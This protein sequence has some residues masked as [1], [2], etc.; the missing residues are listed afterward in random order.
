MV[1]N[2]NHHIARFRSPRAFQLIATQA[3]RKTCLFIF[4][5]LMVTGTMML[6]LLALLWDADAKDS[7]AGRRLPLLHEQE[8]ERPWHPGQWVHVSQLEDATIRAARGH[9]TRL[10]SSPSPSETQG[11]PPGND[12]GMETPRPASGTSSDDDP[13]WSS[14]APHPEPH[15]GPWHDCS[16]GPFPAED[17]LPGSPALPVTEELR[18]HADPHAL[19]VTE[20]P[21]GHPDQDCLPDSPSG[22]ATAASNERPCNSGCRSRSTMPYTAEHAFPPDAEP[23]TEEP[24]G[25][26]AP[27]H[28]PLLIPTS[29]SPSCDSEEAANSTENLSYDSDRTLHHRGALRPSPHAVPVTELPRGHSVQDRVL[30]SPPPVRQQPSK[31]RTSSVTGGPALWQKDWL[32]PAG[33]LTQGAADHLSTTSR[34]PEI[35]DTED[36]SALQARTWLMLGVNMVQAFEQAW[37][38]GEHAPDWFWDIVD[39]GGDMCRAGVQVREMATLFSDVAAQRQDTMEEYY[40]QTE[41]IR[42]RIIRAWE[43]VCAHYFTCDLPLPHGLNAYEF[44]RLS[45]ESLRQQWHRAQLAGRQLVTPRDHDR[46]ARSRSPAR[47]QARQSHSAPSQGT[48]THTDEAGRQ[49]GAGAGPDEEADITALV[50]DKWLL[51]PKPKQRPHNKAKVRHTTTETVILRA[52]WKRGGNPPLRA[53]PA[54]PAEPSTP[55]PDRPAAAN[56]TCPIELDDDEKE[57][58]VI[59]TNTTARD[60]AVEVWQALFEFEPREAIDPST[61]PVVPQSTLDNIVET[62]L[63]KP[64]SEYQHMVM[65]STYFLGRVADDVYSAMER[66]RALRARLRDEPSG[67]KGPDSDLASLMQKSLGE[68]FSPAKP[69]ILY[70]LKEGLQALSPGAA[71]ARARQLQRRL[72]DHDGPLTVDRALLDS[73][74]WCMPRVKQNERKEIGTFASLLGWP[75]GGPSWKGD[76]SPRQSPRRSAS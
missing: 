18:G 41:P 13:A 60:E 55:P 22:R 54:E 69:Q 72:K 31:P 34:K 38:D 32:L 62:L 71:I 39:M 44:A 11:I 43:V 51:K 29:G 68:A 74:F 75:T 8:V 58:V 63:D 14:P 24:R 33:H 56:T 25:R 46:H 61:V 9:T 17:P 20:V 76:V 40:M 4:N 6:V 3:V 12:L 26:S 27:V 45:E 47:T 50:A 66:A 53:R 59:E 16:P 35:Y 36:N 21:Q 7:P 19:P 23:A 48:N 67:S 2:L 49:E 42:N 37:S 15:Q 5:S 65:A 52:P 70:L 10:D 57:E 30:D 64:E 73:A 1:H 28:P